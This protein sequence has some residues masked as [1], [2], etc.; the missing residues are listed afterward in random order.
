[1]PGEPQ[2]LRDRGLLHYELKN[3][4]LAQQDLK[5]YLRSH[6]KAPDSQNIQK[7]LERIGR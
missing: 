7:I 3:Y 6:P 1:M 4:D 5:A 2:Q